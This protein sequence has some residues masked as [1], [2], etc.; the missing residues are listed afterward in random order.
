MQKESYKT[1]NEGF[2][3]KMTGNRDKKG[4]VLVGVLWIVA[5]LMVIATSVGQNSRLDT[6]VSTMRIEELRCRWACRAGIETA[7]G[8]LNEDL[9]ESDNLTEFWSDNDEDFNDVSLEKCWFSVRVIDESS[10]LNINTVTKEQLMELPYMEEDIAD[11]IIDWRDG[12]DTP[13]AG[14]VEGGYYET[15]PIGYKIRNGPFKTI[16]E[17]LLVK[18]VTE[19]LFYGEDT[20]FNGLL[21]YNEKDG[22]ESPPVDDR[23]DVLDVGWIAYL[24]CYSYDGN[25]DAEG[26]QKVNI[27]QG[28]ERQLQSSLGISRSQAQWIV[29]K[30][31]NNNFT[32][33]ADLI[34]D[35]SSQQPQQ[36]SQQSSQQD[37][38]QSPQQSSQQSP[39]QDSQR[40][41][42][43]GPQSGS[44]SGSNQAEPL[45]LQTFYEIADKI[46]VDSG[47][48]IAGKVN[49]NTASK[50][51]L[52]ALL[53]DSEAN[54]EIAENIVAY[55]TGLTEGMQSIADLMSSGLVNQNTFTR[56]ANN[57]TVRSNVFTIRC[58]ATADRGGVNGTTLQTEVVVDRSESPY[59][60]LYWYQGASN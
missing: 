44:Q 49:I 27:N 36:S 47:N 55:R 17:L 30:R 22:D 29:E 24:T 40:G 10:K 3:E 14:G 19:E 1:K 53:G 26:N 33:I 15:L 11:A 51:V 42:Q 9:R 52:L 16:R 18:G 5:M 41:P 21:D 48:Q 6:K 50:G 58:S 57:I 59:T 25:V 12:D 45:D 46:T 2:A 32:S 23:D 7:I 56:I 37:S 13:N 54:M 39:Q 31:Q 34:D 35:S 60:T 8:V 43:S 38:Q 28:N 20:N 4:L